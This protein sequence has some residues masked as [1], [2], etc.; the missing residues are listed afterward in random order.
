MSFTAQ[1]R[2]DDHEL[3]RVYSDDEAVETIE[4]TET[5]QFDGAVDGRTWDRDTLDFSPT[6]TDPVDYVEPPTLADLQA[7]IDTL[8]TAW[9]EGS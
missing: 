1:Y 4:N 6:P 7:Q 9:L 3:L 5:K 2:I 8:T